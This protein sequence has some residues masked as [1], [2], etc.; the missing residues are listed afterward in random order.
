MYQPY[1]NVPNEPAKNN[2]NETLN[3]AANDVEERRGR[4]A[5]WSRRIRESDQA[6]FSELFNAM[7]DR[8]ARYAYG[9]TKDEAS[10]YDVLQDVFLKLWEMRQKLN[11]E[12]SL[13][14]L[15]YTMTRNASLNVNRR[16]GYLVH[17]EKVMELKDVT[18]SVAAPSSDERLDAQ[19][20]SEKINQW[21]DELPERR[22]E[23]FVLSRRHECSHKEISEIMGLSER[24][25]NTHIFLA[26]KH[27][28]SKL[29]ALQ[30]DR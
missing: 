30:N 10:A 26:L 7:S 25:V 27:L 13:Q 17:D 18:S 29:D 21:I 28:R 3:V 8:L 14:S 22:K 23:A 15:L 11:P 16:Q 1:N 4:F 2:L 5:R 12:S 24:T 19:Y 20:L 9:I 6:A